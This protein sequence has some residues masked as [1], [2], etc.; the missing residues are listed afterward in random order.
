MAAYNKFS[1]FVFDLVSGLH[2]FDAHTYKVALT[3]TVPSSTMAV[4]ANITEIAAGSGYSSGGGT[5]SIT[6]AG[7][8]GVTT[9][10]GSDVTF[11]AAGGTIATFR[12]AVFYDSTNSVSSGPL[13]AWWDSGAAQSITD[14]NSFVVDVSTTTG[15]FTIA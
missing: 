9:V 4:L 15:V 1:I 7:T 3:N 11:T 13:I 5:T 6:V 10:I 8:S 14:G 12:Y 2:D